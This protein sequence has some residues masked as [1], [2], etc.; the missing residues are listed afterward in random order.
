MEYRIGRNAD[1]EIVINKQSV[2]RYHG[3]LRITENGIIY[4]DL[5]S[6]NGSF[7]NGN[8]VSGP[9]LIKERDIIK[10]GT[11]LIPWRNY[12]TKGSDCST[13]IVNVEQQH[14]EIIYKES[15]TDINPA[16]QNS[17]SKESSNSSTNQ[18]VHQQVIVNNNIKA[19]NGLGV[20]GFVLG[21]IGLFTPFLFLF[22]FL[23][24]LFSFIGVFKEPRGLAIAGLVISIISLIL[25]LVLVAS[26]NG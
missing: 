15:E 4:E 12:L 16:R 11:E 25:G 8:R 5:G 24:F 13:E 23:G 10:L 9:V 17:S 7:I 18:Q 19:S 3:V 6:S 21:L 22:G 1:N 14:P 20:A 26:I 2:S